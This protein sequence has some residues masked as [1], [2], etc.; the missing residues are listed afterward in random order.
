MGGMIGEATLAMLYVPLFFYL[1]DQLTERRA[2]KKKKAES[3]P[4]V[5]TPPAGPDSLVEGGNS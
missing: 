4:A 1:F 2:R 3:P 5:E